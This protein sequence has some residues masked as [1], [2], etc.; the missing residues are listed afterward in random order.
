M[1]R[2]LMIHNDVGD[3]CNMVM[4]RYGHDGNRELVI[5]NRVDGNDSVHPPIEK[6]FGIFLDAVGTVAVTGYEEKVPFF[7]QTIFYPAEHGRG[8]PFADL[9]NNH[10]NGKT[11]PGAQGAS[12]Q[13]R[14]VVELSRGGED[15]VFRL[16]GYSV[17]AARPI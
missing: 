4:S 15:Q 8:V 11:A 5:P 17:G 2:A 3:I 9:G 10:A 12:Q 7:D 13:I 16:L 1:G 14:S 6:G